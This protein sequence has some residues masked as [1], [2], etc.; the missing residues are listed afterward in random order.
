MT[1]N[2]KTYFLDY[3]LSLHQPPQPTFFM[4]NKHGSYMYRITNCESTL[5]ALSKLKTC[6]PIS[7]HSGNESLNKVYS[8]DQDGCVKDDWLGKT[9]L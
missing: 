9:F 3:C 2:M 5:S 8:L 6:Q 7:V 1:F 4:Y